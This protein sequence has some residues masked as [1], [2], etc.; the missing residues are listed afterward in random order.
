MLREVD[1]GANIIHGSLKTTGLAKL[2]NKA[3]AGVAIQDFAPYAP[4]NNLYSFFVGAPI[5]VAGK[6]RG[7][8]VLQFLTTEYDS[9][10]SERSGMGFSGESYLIGEDDGIT[11]Y[12][13]IRQVKQSQA[14]QQRTDPYIELALAGK[15][16]QA[17]KIGSTGQ[18][19]L[20]SYSPIR[21]PG[22]HWAILSTIAEEEVRAPSEQLAVIIMMLVAFMAIVL[23]YLAVIISRKIIHPLN[24]LDQASK[25]IAAGNYATRL[26]EFP[27]TELA[28]L[29]TTFN[30]MAVDIGSKTQELEQA[31]EYV[32]I[33]FS[34]MADGLIVVSTENIVKT[35]NPAAFDLLEYSV[36]NE[37]IGQ[38]I[39]TF[40]SESASVAHAA[41]LQTQTQENYSDSFSDSFDTT[42]L[43]KSGSTLEV[44][45]SR[46][47]FGSR[48]GAAS[49]TVFVFRDISADKKVQAA[50]KQAHD[51]LQESEAGLK[52]ILAYAMDAII[53]IDGQGRVL[54][55]NPAAEKLFGYVQNEVL[56]KDI[57][58]FIIPQTF[59]QAHRQGLLRHVEKGYKP[60]NIN[61]RIEITG[62]TK[63]G[64]TVDLEIALTCV[65]QHGE[66]NFTAFIHDIT[67]RKKLL[68][69][70]QE[71]LQIAERSTQ[72]K[73]EFLANMS[74]EIRTPMNAIIG[75]THLS[76]QTD[77]SIQQ[78]DYLDKIHSSANALLRIINDILDFSKIEAGK[79]AVEIIPFHLSD[80]LNDL[81]TLT[82]M[83]IHE[84]EL[85]VIFSIAHNVPRTLL[86]DPTRLGQILINLTSNAAKFTASGEIVLSVE[87]IDAGDEA[88]ILQFAVKDTGIGM[89]PEQVKLLFQA[90][91]QADG[92]TTR[93]Y[94]GTGLG[95]TI[96]KRLVEM[97]GGKIW[98]ESAQGQ[99]SQ[100][101][102]TTRFGVP[103]N[104][105]EK[106]LLLPVDLQK[107]RVLVIDDNQASQDMLRVAL[108]SFSFQV[109]TVSSG[110]AGL[111]ELEK[112]RQEETPFDL[113]LLD[114]RMPQL[115]GAQTFCCLKSLD[116]PFDLPTMFL[117]PHTEQ[118]D[119]RE[120]IGEVQPEGYLDKP[121]Q[122][123]ALFDA[124]M[125][126][127]GKEGLAS[128][129]A[130]ENARDKDSFVPPGAGIGGAR[131]LL[132][133]DNDIN[134]QVGKELLEMAGVVVEIANNCAE[135]VQRVTETEFELVLMDIQMPVMDGYQATCKIR[136]NPER[137]KLPIVA[138]TANVMVQ[139]LARCWD[140]GMD[141]HIA[142]PIDPKK[143]FHA[144]NKWIQPMERLSL[145]QDDSVPQK[146]RQVQREKSFPA[147]SG[148]N[149]EFGLSRVGGNV[150]LF[151]TLLGKFCAN[152]G[153]CAIEIQAAVDQ[154]DSY[155]ARRMAHTLKGVAGTIGAL[156]LQ[157]MAK[158]VE[159]SLLVTAEF[160]QEL[161][162][163]IDSIRQLQPIT[164]E[165]NSAQKPKVTVVDLAVLL[166]TLALL[167]THVVKKMPK[168]CH[169]ILEQLAE[170][171]FPFG[172]ETDL[173]NLTKL[174]KRYKMK[175]ANSVIDAMVVQLTRSQDNGG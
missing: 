6:T 3:L 129:T 123:S 22:L 171:A 26:P 62:Q 40:F 174:I 2:F 67:E 95:L 126:I 132:V 14:G 24:V 116:K 138:M 167:K 117:V 70:L 89:T 44:A 153:N 157:A 110:M 58:D 45:V 93:K 143:L 118:A 99:G 31:K 71:A 131:V 73:S 127:F 55:F 39:E 49:G 139:D 164:Q 96:S 94:G 173:E 92:G 107:K 87:R 18:K 65:F 119:V 88:V 34:S 56:G 25:N 68:D 63:N 120:Q 141:G 15:S 21:I 160:E 47:S 23:G 83:K 38:H 10:L 147:M 91:S 79:L 8:V 20:V 17:R 158:E 37:L 27:Q 100:F 155:L 113:L 115:D 112:M 33:I 85:E 135:A 9:W 32:E 30:Q 166:Q 90:F 101:F 19:E 72:F 69:S 77:L 156:R 86:G 114:W 136:E 124:V 1:I 51:K 150:A 137:A 50:L 66:Y 53:T 7:I 48:K 13:S 121:V 168:N 125:T 74:H 59:R 4:S 104:C 82:I 145:C 142:K 75:L 152:H 46:S 28:S 134:Q 29:M 102:F 57:A 54:S 140:V 97:M 133:E 12:R 163:V 175:E 16:G 35:A 41:G 161:A 151:R 61:R 52:S 103:E 105:R 64:E 144:L 42:A 108:E 162:L 5:K 36:A 111:I 106:P 81:S 98:V 130:L 84:K 154:E 128:V 149:T 148:I 78:R 169:P 172:M 43:T 159:S 76:L 11:S 165:E 80:V 146:N 122:L 170:M 60:L 109:S